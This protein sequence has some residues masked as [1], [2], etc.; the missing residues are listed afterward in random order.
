MRNFS[1]DASGGGVMWP[2]NGVVKL[3]VACE[4]EKEENTTFF[5]D[6]SEVFGMD[7]GADFPPELQK[8][9]RTVATKTIRSVRG[10]ASTTDRAKAL[11]RLRP[12][13]RCEQARAE[14]TMASDV[15]SVAIMK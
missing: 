8:Q 5:Q 1:G 10:A 15:A 11:E 12:L 7:S 9:V 3:E 14:M 2:E 13:G 4:K 6:F